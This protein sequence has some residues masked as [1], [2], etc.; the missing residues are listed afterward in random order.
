MIIILLKFTLN[1]KKHVNVVKFIQKELW[2]CFFVGKH[3]KWTLDDKVKIVKEFK[4][5]AT[6]SYLNNKYGISG[7]GTVSR[8]NKKI[9]SLV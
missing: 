2:R 3:K 9:R 5:G 1:K 4:D 7:C 6:I 8:R